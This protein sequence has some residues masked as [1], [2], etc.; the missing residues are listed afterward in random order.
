MPG[1]VGGLMDTFFEPFMAAFTPA[2]RLAFVNEVWEALRPKLC[3]ADGRW[4]ADYVLLRFAAS[5]ILRRWG[6]KTPNRLASF[7]RSN[8]VTWWQR[9]ML[10]RFRPPAPKGNGTAVGPLSSCALDV[11]TGTT[12]TEFQFGA[13]LKPSWDTTMTGLRPLCS[14]PDRGV[15]SAQKT[16]PRLSAVASAASSVAPKAPE[17]RPPARDRDRRGCPPFLRRRSRWLHS[18][19]PCAPAGA[20]FRWRT[21]RQPSRVASPVARHRGGDGT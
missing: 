6:G 5:T 19:S 20:S 1:D 16:S 2:D 14:E 15:R 21:W 12:T 9:A 17:T 18:A 3:D 8:V 7:S 4:T 10:D 11:E 13:R